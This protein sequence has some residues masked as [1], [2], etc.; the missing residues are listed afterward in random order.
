M[1]I[2][3][4]INTVIA[5]IFTL[6]SAYQ[7][8]YVFVALVKKP[9]QLS[10]APY[11][12]F[13]ALISARNE[14]AVIGQLIESIQNQN[15]PSDYVDIYVVADN[16]TDNTAQVAEDAGAT[17][18][19]RFNRLEVGK[20]YSLDFLLSRIHRFYP[21]KQYDGYFVFDADNLLDENYIREMNKTFSAGYRIITSYR[22]SKN[23]SSNWISASYSIWFL[24]EAKSLNNARMLLGTSCAISGTGFLVHHEILDELGGWKHFLLTEDI[25]FTVDS[26]L[27]GEKVGY[28]HNAVLYDEQPVSFVQSWNQRLR[29]SKGNL[30]IARN[31]GGQLLTGIFTAEHKFACFD[32][33]MTVLLMFVL[34]SVAIICNCAGIYVSLL[35]KDQ[36]FISIFWSLFRSLCSLY[37]LFYAMGLLTV[38]SEWKKIHASAGKKILYSFSFPFF[39]ATYVPIT[40]VAL[41]KKVKWTPIHHTIAKSLDEVRAKN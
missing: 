13:A 8:F 7:F 37:L 3:Q 6:C 5:V 21:D 30:Q 35:A 22:N 15:Y 39:M 24:R 17:V 2:L 38:I 4:T 1:E 32:M 11:H 12:R 36:A 25:E 10:E 33:A 18:W 40:A 41:F 27:H 26:I 20:G 9:L 34:S 28:C 19:E 16:C 31:Y 29:W 14:E 23:F